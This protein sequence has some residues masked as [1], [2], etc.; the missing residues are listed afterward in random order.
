MIFEVNKQTVR[1]RIYKFDSS[2][3]CHLP[4]YQSVESLSEIS[5]IFETDKLVIPN[6]VS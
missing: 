6:L 5:F 1:Q 3:T 4:K 2:F